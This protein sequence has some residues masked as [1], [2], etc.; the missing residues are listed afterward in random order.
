[1]IIALLGNF[2]APWC[3]EV[4]HTR[5]LESLGHTVV[6]IQETNTST[7]QILGRAAQAN[8][9]VWV[10]PHEVRPTGNLTMEQV[11]ARLRIPRV[12][13]HL[14]LFYGLPQ[15]W[16]TYRNELYI[17]GLDHFFTADGPLADWLN[18]NTAVKGHY[19]PPGV[20][21]EETYCA[22]PSADRFDV[23]F[24]GSERYH[25]EWPYRPKL[26]DWLRKTYGNRFRLYGQ[27]AGIVVR[28]AAL[29][30]VY[31]D[32]KVIVGDT[33]CPKFTY[34]PYF[35]DRIPET[36]GRGGF[37]IHPRITGLEDDYVD[38]E[39]LVLYQY[40]DWKGLRAKIDHY[41][42]H[43]EERERIRLAGHEHVKNNYTYR[44]RWETILHEVL[45][46]NYVAARP[47]RVPRSVMDQPVPPSGVRLTRNPW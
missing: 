6:Q 47:P 10:H 3:S 14:D 45:G 8:L 19:L 36:L 21:A 22:T 15:R 29:N 20:L 11:L 23:G 25:P 12:A 7:D 30:Q 16:E 39:H 37:L 32:A 28:G 26:I 42:T 38:G 1:M 5:S 33:F 43:D 44:H 2:Q 35:S 4:H 46:E 31:A 13:Y 41:L 24:V 9:F 18:A 27:D 40:N 17:R 34:G